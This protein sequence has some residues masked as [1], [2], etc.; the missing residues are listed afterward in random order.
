MNLRNKHLI[1][2]LLI[3]I[4]AFFPANLA[5]SLP[6]E[7][8]KIDDNHRRE[9]T[10]WLDQQM[11]TWPGGQVTGEGRALKSLFLNANYF[12]IQIWRNREIW[13]ARVQCVAGCA[14]KQ[15]CRGV[16]VEEARACRACLDDCKVGHKLWTCERTNYW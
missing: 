11:R 16:S 14:S 1:Y 4:F 7:C 5:H 8:E 15:S 6:P 9:L 10:A 3:A 12:T 2:A 13:I